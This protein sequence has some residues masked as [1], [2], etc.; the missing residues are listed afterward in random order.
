LEDKKQLLEILLLDKK[1]I[2]IG[3]QKESLNEKIS[4]YLQLKNEQLNFLKKELKNLMVEFIKIDL[5]LLYN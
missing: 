4:L 3:Q 5:F 2:N 1:V